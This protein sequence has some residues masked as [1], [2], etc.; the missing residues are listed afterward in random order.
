AGVIPVSMGAQKRDLSSSSK[1]TLP[2]RGDESDGGSSGE[3][4][5]GGKEGDSRGND[6]GSSGN[7]EGKSGDDSGSDDGTK[8]ETGS[9]SEEKSSGGS[10]SEASSAGGENSGSEQSSGT[11]G[12]NGGSGDGA[13]YEVGLGSCGQTNSN[14]EL[15]D[16][17]PPGFMES[18][19]AC[20][21]KVTVSSNGKSVPVTI[22]DTCPSCA[23]GSLDLSPAAFKKLDDLNNG[24]IP[25][26]WSE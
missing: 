1:H 18:N 23:E 19:G 26:S 24:R 16:A 12:G 13:Y 11:K 6:S 4:H 17:A 22:V 3:N 15:V 14:D 21:K 8:G 7:S 9:G 10:N 2:K 25:I 5:S 20:G